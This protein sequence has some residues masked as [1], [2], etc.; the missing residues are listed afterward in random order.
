M[1]DIKQ[2]IDERGF[3]EGDYLGD[4][5]RNNHEYLNTGKS[6]RSTPTNRKNGRCVCCRKVQRDKHY[7]SHKEQYV[8]KAIKWQKENPE[9]ASKSRTICKRKR[10]RRDGC[11]LQGNISMWAALKKVKKVPTVLDLVKIEQKRYW[12]ERAKTPE[13]KAEYQRHLYKTSWKYNFMQRE[14]NQRKKSRS[15]GNYVERKSAEELRDRFL[16]FNNCCAYCS[17]ELI[18][19]T[20]EFDHVVPTS[21]NGP[22]ILAN[23]VP[24]CRECNK[25]KRDK[26][27]EGWFKSQAFYS[28][29]QLK[30]IKEVLALAFSIV[31][32]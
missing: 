30:K 32:Q 29:K 9:K 16:A 1:T 10:R 24:S 7:L 21:N 15:K 19:S 8:D 28:E 4:L 22:D 18:F 12:N 27:M 20:V 31:D 23:L 11:D 17:K 6:I 13:G 2:W 25:D 5:C 3:L 26:D 14:K